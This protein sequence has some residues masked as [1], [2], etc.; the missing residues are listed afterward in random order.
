[1]SSLYGSN[2]SNDDLI[3]D[4]RNY[5][6]QFCL[7]LSLLN[8]KFRKVD[9]INVN[10]K[11]VKFLKVNKAKLNDTQGIYMFVLKTA[12]KIDLNGN[13]QLILY[14]GQTKNLKQRFGQ[15]FNYESSDE[16]SDFLKRCMVLLWKGKLEFHY[17]ETESLTEKDLTN[18]EYDLIDSIVPPMNN[19]FRGELLKTHVKLNAPR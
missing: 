12:N 2:I 11:S 14:V 9:S 4:H 1:M 19:R 8:I 7:N 18:V 3:K 16:P 15:Y 5:W 13:G 10:W 6:R 17:F